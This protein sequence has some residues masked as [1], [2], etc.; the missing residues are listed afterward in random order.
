MFAR[1]GTFHFVALS[2]RARAG[3]ARDWGVYPEIMMGLR[4]LIEAGHLPTPRVTDLGVLSEPT[5]REAHRRL[6]A[7]H[8]TGKLALTVGGHG[9]VRHTPP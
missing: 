7:G 9:E 3:T 5:I 6:E 1:S 8:V 2:A 4:D